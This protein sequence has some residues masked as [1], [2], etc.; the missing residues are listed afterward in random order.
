MD[1]VRRRYND[2]LWL[3]DL[4]VRAHPGLFVPPLPPKNLL[5]EG[6]NTIEER[7]VDLTRFLQRLRASPIFGKHAALQM[8]LSTYVAG[9]AWASSGPQCV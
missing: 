1:S 7:P 4:L 8:F 3:R 2:F 9:F 5:L 6:K